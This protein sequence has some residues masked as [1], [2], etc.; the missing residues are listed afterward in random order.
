MEFIGADG[1]KSSKNKKK[2][3]RSTRSGAEKSHKSVSP[4]TY[5]QVEQKKTKKRAAEKKK[6]SMN[7]QNSYAD[8]SGE[9]ENEESQKSG[10]MINKWNQ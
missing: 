7:E 6:E 1:L 5:S 2:I 3:E 9:V 10:I 4:R 8:I